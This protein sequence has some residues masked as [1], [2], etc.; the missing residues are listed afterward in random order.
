MTK[1]ENMFSFNKGNVEKLITGLGYSITE[2]NHV[3]EENGVIQRCIVCNHDITKN[4]LGMIIPG[5]KLLLCDNPAC[6]SKYL[7][8]R[9]EFSNRSKNDK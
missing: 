1:I 2:P 6:F 7:A 3:I 9:T 8:V 5:S 4:N